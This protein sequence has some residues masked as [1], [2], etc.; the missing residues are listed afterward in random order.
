MKVTYFKL[1]VCT[2][3]CPLHPAVKTSWTPS[4]RSS[5]LRA[6]VKGMQRHQ[7]DVTSAS[8]FTAASFCLLLSDM[9]K[10]VWRK[11]SLIALPKS[12]HFHLLLLSLSSFSHK[13]QIIKPK[14]KMYIYFRDTVMYQLC[15]YQ[16]FLALKWRFLS[17]GYV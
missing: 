16:F 1:V 15:I 11:F 17:K 8:N 3:V 5:H 6:E 7:T 4:S 2:P 13:K 10:P 9:E 12:S 14:S